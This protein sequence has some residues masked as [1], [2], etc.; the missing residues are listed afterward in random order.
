[1]LAF[2]GSLDERVLNKQTR[3]II[4][5]GKHVENIDLH[6]RFGYA[7]SRVESIY[8]LLLD[9]VEKECYICNKEVLSAL[10]NKLTQEKYRDV[11]TLGMI[12]GLFQ[13]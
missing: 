1:M 13:T 4:K 3:H 7:F 9:T 8:K 6:I 2:W 12:N 11:S 10:S 5:F